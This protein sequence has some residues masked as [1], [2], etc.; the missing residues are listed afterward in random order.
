M[1]MALWIVA[2]AGTAVV[3]AQ[4]AAVPAAA[5]PVEQARL[6]AAVAELADLRRTIADEKL[7]LAR[8]LTRLE[9]EHVA[10]RQEYDSVRRKLDNRALDV[11]NLKQEIRRLEQEQAYLSNLFAEYA[12][13]F[14][15]RLHIAE[16]RRY[17]NVVTAAKTAHEQTDLPPARR[18]A[19]QLALVEAGLRRIGEIGGGVQFEGRAAGEDGLVVPGQ[20]VLIGPIAYFAAAAS[21]LAGIAE[22]RLGSLEPTVAPFANPEHEQRVREFVVSGEGHIPFDASLGS[23]RK[24]EQTRETLVQHIRKGGPVMVP[25][26]GLAALVV[27]LALVKFIALVFVRLPTPDRMAP[28]LEAVRRADHAAARSAAAALGGPAGWLLTAGANQLGGSKDLIEEA[29]YERM[30]DLRFRFNRGLPFIA[31]GAATAPLLGLLGTVTGIISTFKLITVFGS[32]DVKMLSAGISEALIT[33]EFG[34]LVAIPSL[35]MHAFLS[36]KARALQDRMEQMAVS[37]LGAVAGAPTA[38][39]EAAT[40]PPPAPA[41]PEAASP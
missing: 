13:N 3:Y 4:D 8:D 37:F 29:M 25:I 18:F 2:V 1:K 17:E 19:R 34:L 38:G 11:N 28:L 30:L 27:L 40:V 15:T 41:V 14:E 9:A 24:I 7:P 23:A 21:P 16:V 26:L 12:R 32:G 39:L 6:N 35:L 10:V 22:Q 20:F 31:V 5:A 33:T 36:R